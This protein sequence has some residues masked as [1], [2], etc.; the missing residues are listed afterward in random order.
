MEVKKNPKKDLTQ[1]SNLYFVAGLFMVLALSYTALEWKTFYD[2]PNYDTSMHLDEDLNEELE[3]FKIEQPKPPAPPITPEEILVVEDDEPIIETVID[4]PEPGPDTK[5]LKME[6]IDVGVIE[7][8]LD[9][10]FILVEEAPVFPGC[11][12]ASDKKAC[13]NEKIQ[14]HVRK[15]F[16]YP[17]IAQEMGIQGKVYMHFV[18]QKD[19]S[20]GNIQIARSPDKNLG[21]EAKRI[22]TKLPQMTPAKQRGRAVRVPFNIPITFKL[23]Q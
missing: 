4:I 15:N 23:Q 22:I 16:R 18:I 13:F 11:E 5:I 12:K 7:E 10:P 1:N 17:E 6:D 21:S 19:G 14:K 9:V 2:E 8:D 20:I 3:V